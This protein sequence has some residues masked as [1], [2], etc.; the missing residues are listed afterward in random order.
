MVTK[1]IKRIATVRGK[2]LGGMKG[3]SSAT[4]SV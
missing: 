3:V 4:N 1:L 2:F